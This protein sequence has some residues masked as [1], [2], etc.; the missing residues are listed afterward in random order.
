MSRGDTGWTLNREGRPFY[1]K[2]VGGSDRLEL[3][4]ECGGNSIRTWAIDQGTDVLLDSAQNLGLTV[5]LGHWLGHERH[6]FS[7]NNLDQITQQMERVRRDVEK[8]RDHPAL[9]MWALGNEMEGYEQGDNPAIWNHIESLA[10]MVKQLDPHH[11]TMTVIGEMAGRRIEAIHKLCPS[12]DII[13]INAYGGATSLAKRYRELGGT[14]PFVAT[15]FGPFGPWEVR[16]DKFNMKT[17]SSSTARAAAYSNSYRAIR[18]EKELALGS[19]AF[20][21][22]HK[23]EFTKTWFGMFLPTGERLEP[24]DVMRRLWSG[25][26]PTNEC[27]RIRRL[28]LNQSLP[29]KANRTVRARLQVSDPDGDQLSVRWELAAEADEVLGGD[30]QAKPTDFS[31]AIR[32]GNRSSALIRVPAVGGRYRLYVFVSDGRGGGATANIPIFVDGPKGPAMPSKVEMPFLVYGDE[33]TDPPFAATGWMGATDSIAMDEHCTDNP[34]TGEK[35]LRVE[36]RKMM[37]WAGAVWQNPPHDWGEL[38]GGYD[39]SE[40]RELSFWVRGSVGG[41][42]VKF[43]FGI[44]RDD[45]RY[46]D[47][48]RFEQEYTLANTWQQIRI[49]LTSYD[50]SRIKSGFMWFV[51]GQGMPVTFFLDEIRYQ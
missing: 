17:E 41:E 28:S 1:I 18:A 20:L 6:G 48:S 27:P 2:G 7:Y 29:L 8:Y 40:A 3:L 26:S 38:P 24:V 4:K 15:E 33:L 39:L 30:F 49:D 11:P 50:L 35:C 16:A 51:G 19:F 42:K 13:G 14:K 44:I 22:G 37:D 32:D 46:Y 47:S 10:R 45:M 23:M 5:T 43:G 9:L 36:Y 25:K 31:D 12:V 21:W 34:K